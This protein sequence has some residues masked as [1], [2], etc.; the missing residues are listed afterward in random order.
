MSH[1]PL[2]S[3]R[4]VSFQYCAAFTKRVNMQMHDEVVRRK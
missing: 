1:F 4:Q 2:D 3:F